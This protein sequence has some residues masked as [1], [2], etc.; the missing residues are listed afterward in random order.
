MSLQIDR[1]LYW[2]CTKKRDLVFRS[3]EAAAEHVAEI[4]PK[5][6][7]AGGRET[8]FERLVKVER[9]DDNWNLTG[10]SEEMWMQATLILW[11][12]EREDDA[13]KMEVVKR[14]G[15]YRDGKPQ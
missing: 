12:K 7:E 10:V 13:V 6:T 14:Y 8:F 2:L 5:M 1:S 9:R 15:K 11:S 3:I 4:M